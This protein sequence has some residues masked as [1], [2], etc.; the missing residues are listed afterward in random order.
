MSESITLFSNIDQLMIIYSQTSSSNFVLGQ[1]HKVI[2]CPKWLTNYFRPCK[3]S[4][5]VVP[6]ML[7]SQLKRN[8][9]LS[10]QTKEP[11]MPYFFI[12]AIARA[13]VNNTIGLAVEHIPSIDSSS[14]GFVE[15]RQ[16]LCLVSCNLHS[17]HRSLC[18][19]CDPVG[20]Q[21]SITCT[22]HLYWHITDASHLLWDTTS[23]F[24]YR[25]EKIL[26]FWIQIPKIA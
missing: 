10:S 13:T 2:F 18:P 25:N 4:G 14:D 26:L 21:V 20:P 24:C 12:I 3:I 1:N 19:L 9:S 7:V 23:P 5:A 22:S 6:K 11:T 8:F 15:H 16:Q 17:K